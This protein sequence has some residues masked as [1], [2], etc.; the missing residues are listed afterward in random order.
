[1]RALF[2][3]LVLAFS[4]GNTECQEGTYPR[5]HRGCVTLNAHGI[6]CPR[7]GPINP[8]P[9]PSGFWLFGLGGLAVAVG[10]WMQKRG[11]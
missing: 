6:D 9:E 5:P 8:V 2:L 1:M 3:A 11:N 7:G 10:V 4:L